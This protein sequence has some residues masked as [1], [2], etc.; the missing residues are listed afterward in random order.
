MADLRKIKH[1]FFD[2]DD[3]LWDYDRNSRVVLEEMFVVFGLDS[4]LQCDFETFFR[5][6]K[7]INLDLWSLFYKRLIDKHGLRETRW[8]KVFAHFNNTGYNNHAALSQ[9]FVER[10][11]R[12]TCLKEGC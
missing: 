9:F 7:K 8:Q 1:L 11:H 2:L 10:S 6:Y 4:K 3:T 5:V 12:G